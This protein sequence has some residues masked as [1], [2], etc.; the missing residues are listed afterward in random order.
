MSVMC[1]H[2]FYM[3]LAAIP[4]ILCGFVVLDSVVVL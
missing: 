1:V 3:F 4:F 2:T